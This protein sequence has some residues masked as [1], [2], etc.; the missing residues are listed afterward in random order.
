MKLDNLKQLYIHE[1]NDLYSAENQI[2]EAL[3]KM[4]EA[5][6]DSRL[7]NAFMKHLELT[8]HQVRRLEEIFDQLG[9][10]A[11]S[12]KCEGMKGIIKE[13]ES[14]IKK[15]KSFFRGD[16]DNDVLDAALIASAQRVEHYE[17]SGYGTARTYAKHLGYTEQA[18]L[19]Q[20]TLDEESR[21]DRELTELAESS[22]NIKA[23]K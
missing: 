2:L 15:D 13:G 23:A 21:T 19:L 16:I 20:Q 10:K 17:I 22:V 9:E 7:K 12:S 11:E 8:K 18:S 4:V 1:L 14:F 5:T 3:P 6:D